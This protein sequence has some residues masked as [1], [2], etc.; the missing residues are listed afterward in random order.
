MNTPDVKDIHPHILN[1]TEW[2]EITGIVAVLQ[3]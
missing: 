3:V 1:K 2:E